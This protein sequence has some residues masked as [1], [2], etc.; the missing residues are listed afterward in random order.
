MLDIKPSADYLSRSTGSGF[1]NFSM[2]FAGK[3]FILNIFLTCFFFWYFFPLKLSFLN[4]GGHFYVFNRKLIVFF[5]R[6]LIFG[7]G[8]AQFCFFLHILPFFQIKIYELLEN[9]A[10]VFIKIFKFVL[11]FCISL[12]FLF[13]IIIDTM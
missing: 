2:L 11:I 13:P 1:S 4:K 12:G 7:I 10:S 5:M 3:Q 8:I 9:P 6:P